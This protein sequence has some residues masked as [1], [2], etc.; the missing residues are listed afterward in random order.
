MSVQYV[1]PLL[2]AWARA[3]R[4]LFSPFRLQTWFVLGFASFLSD[5]PTGHAG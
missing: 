4:M 2:R 5:L 3:K 1:P